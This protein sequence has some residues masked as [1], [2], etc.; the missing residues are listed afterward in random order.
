MKSPPVGLCEFPKKP[1]L[2]LLENAYVVI[3]RG[4]GEILIC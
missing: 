4:L 3:P 2:S 1:F